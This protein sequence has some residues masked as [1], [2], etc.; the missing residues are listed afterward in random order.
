VLLLGTLYAVFYS[1]A[2]QNWL[3]GKLGNY[4][5]AQF[6]TKISIGH[7]NY[8]PLYSFELENVLFGDHKEDTLFFAG[9]VK[10]NLAGLN[11]DSSSFRLSQVK[12]DRGYCQ[13]RFYEDGS[14]NIDVLDNILDPNDT[15]TSD[16]PFRLSFD[17]V[18]CKNTRFKFINQTDTSTWEAFAP[19]DEEFYDITAKARDFHIISDSLHFVVDA[20]SLKEKS[21]FEAN[22]IEAIATISPTCMLFE[23]VK[24]KTPYTELDGSYS[25][26]YKNYQCFSN[27]YDEVKLEAKVNSSIVDLKDVA[28]FAYPFKDFPYKL[29]V[30]G[31]GKGTVSNMRLR[32]LDVTFGETGRFKGKADLNGLPDI[33]NTFISA[34]ATEVKANFNDIEYLAQQKLAH[35]LKELGTITFKGKYTGFYTDFVAYG[36]FSTQL[37]TVESDIN[38]K[39]AAQSQDYQ[40]SGNMV[41]N[42]F[43]LGKLAQQNLLGNITTTAKLNGKGFDFKSMVADVTANVSALDL[44]GYRYSNIEV[45]GRLNQEQISASLLLD[46]PNVQLVFNGK[47]DVSQPII[48]YDFKAELANANL[49]ELGIDTSDITISA[50]ANIDFSWKDVDHNNGDIELTQIEV[51]KGDDLYEIKSLVINTT[52]EGIDRNIKIRSDNFDARMQGEFTFM[53][54]PNAVVS[55]LSGLA[56]QYIDASRYVSTSNQNFTFDANINTLYPFN[57]LFFKNTE[58]KNTKLQGG[59][60]KQNNKL[61]LNGYVSEFTYNKVNLSGL[62]FKQNQNNIQHA[63]ILMGLG[64]LYVNDTLLTKDVALKVKFNDNV[65]ETHLIVNDSSSSLTANVRADVH[66]INDSIKTIF[67]TSRIGYLQS[68]FVIN[69]GSEIEYV[70]TAV[71]FNNFQVTRNKIEQVFINGIYGLSDKPEELT[72]RVEGFHLDIANEILP[73]L[74]V[75]INGEVN[76]NLQ[77]TSNSKELI[78]RSDA[79][80]R[81]L[82][83]DHDTIG[84]F[85]LSSKYLKEQRK[86]LAEFKSTKGK[87]RNVEM[88]GYYDFAH[89]SDALNFN[90]RFDESD[91]TSFQAFVK[92]YI[93]LYT[94]SIR[95]KGQLTGSLKAP[96]LNCEVDLMG[97]TLMVEYLKT[98]YSFSSTVFIN[99]QQIKIN[100]TEVRDLYDSKATLTGYITHNRF[101]NPKLNVKL[102]GLNNFQVLNTKSK[103][104]NLFFGTAYVDGGITITGPFNDLIMDATFTGQKGTVVN[105]PI[106]DGFDSGADGLLHFVSHDTISKGN[107]TSRSGSLSGFSINCMMNI[108]KDAEIRIVFDEQQG[109]VIKGRGTGNV[110]LEL[111]RSG[112]FN[113]Y[114]EVEIDEGDYMF[115]AMNLFTKKFTLRRGGTITWTGDPFQGQMNITG[116]YSLRTSVGDIVSSTDKE[117]VAQQRIPVECLLYLRGNLLNPDIKFDM[118]MYDL[119]GSLSGSVVAELQNVLRVWKNDNELMT[120]QVVSLMLFGR[121]TPTNLQNQAGA[122][123]LTAGVNNTLSGFV[124]AQATNFIQQIIPGLDVNVDYHTGNESVRQRT[125]FTA[126]KRVFDNRL[127]IQANVDPIN[128]YQNFLTQYNLVRDGSLKAKAFSRAQSDPIFNRNINTQGVGLYYRKEFDKFNEIF[129]SKKKINQSLQ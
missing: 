77:L 35:Q 68:N 1:N 94:G 103:D 119:A 128:T 90:V 102:S 12:V 8:L 81:N 33:D 18:E 44:N 108:T 70:K 129:L 78:V 112:Q 96:E 114:G 60:N 87:L 84:D 122:N 40:Y 107:E 17:D 47:I 48:K 26:F 24:L 79:S 64:Q 25:M 3:T 85:E 15:T 58:L 89:P 62:I 37:G 6:K 63:D 88:V 20:L 83:L 21:G 32:K 5:S 27:F 86:L 34:E 92:E 126:S 101:A 19:N 49:K 41:L 127:E 45:D 105:I 59:F 38:M 99:E 52:Q 124:S 7:I 73:D 55:T 116:V 97:V 100:P 9:S 57:E 93:T 14:Y 120:Q 23:N 42:E 50:L 39:L 51:I 91:V 111:T 76:G 118:A 65:A 113:M 43:N 61:F 36:F 104:N 82:E 123:N 30:K 46:D 53:D 67:K 56:P 74:S 109:D 69:K 16:M 121:F 71:S 106:S 115:T 80:I 31:E 75:L 10:F 4:L 110:K 72:A 28:F 29:N 125:I 13:I 22:H 2:F 54:I 98:M 95:A 117:A 66:F 11:L